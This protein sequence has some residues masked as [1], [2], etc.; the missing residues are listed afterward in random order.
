VRRQGTWSTADV[1][2]LIAHA[3]SGKYRKD[4]RKRLGI[5]AHVPGIGL[6]RDDKTHRAM[7]RRN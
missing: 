4:R 2:H 7:L 5:S 1:K 3:D 6:W